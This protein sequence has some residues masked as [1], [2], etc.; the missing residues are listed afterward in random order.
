MGLMDTQNSKDLLSSAGQ[1][2]T[3]RTRHGPTDWFQLGK[4]YIK[5]VYIVI[6][7]I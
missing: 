6:L 2:A 7:L 5:A 3:V 1:E 4:E